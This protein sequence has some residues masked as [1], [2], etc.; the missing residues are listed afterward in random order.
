M[1][2]VARPQTAVIKVKFSGNAGGIWVARCGKVRATCTSGMEFAAR[3]VALKLAYGLQKPWPKWEKA[4]ISLDQ[5][6]KD[7]GETRWKASWVGVNHG[8]PEKVAGAQ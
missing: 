1:S 4:E 7:I 6:H 2:I 8:T 3:A 5:D